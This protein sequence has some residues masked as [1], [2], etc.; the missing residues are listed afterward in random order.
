LIRRADRSDI[1]SVEDLRG[2][3][4]SAVKP[5]SLTGWLAQWRVLKA[6]GVEPQSDLK[7]V[8]FEGTNSKVVRSVLDGAADVGAVDADMLLHLVA[9]KQA[10]AASLCYFDQEG[11]PV[12]LTPDVIP[13][14]TDSYPGRVLSKADTVGDDLAEKVVGALTGQN[15]DIRMDHAP[16]QVGFSVACNYAKVRRLLQALMGPRFAESPGFPLPKEYP[17]WL[18]PALVVAG[19]LVAFALIVLLVRNRFRQRETRLLE[20][21]EDTRKE[22]L[23][24]RADRQRIDAIL[25]MAGCGIDIV[26]DDDEIIYADAAIERK[27]GDWHGKKCHQYFCGGDVPCPGC[28]RPRPLAGNE[29]S[30]WDLECSKL[31]ISDDPHARV[32][33]IE[34]ESVRIIGIP[35]RDEGGRWLYGRIHFPVTAFAAST[36]A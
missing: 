22:L 18:A 12:P 15:I 16:Y 19:E 24:V 7:Q 9:C 28:Q 14:A 32:Y 35:F 31:A 27:Y 13:S 25:A 11:R 3:R 10:T 33:Y 20:Q 34:G 1:Q 30:T 2:K 26:D 23:E 8:V 5:W 29:R 17:I 6:H 21:I 36:H 4:L